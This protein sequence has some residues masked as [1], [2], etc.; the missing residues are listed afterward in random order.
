M[1]RS[2]DVSATRSRG[3][4]PVG[5]EGYWRGCDRARA[6]IERWRLTGV[7]GRTASSRL[8][9]LAVVK[10]RCGRTH[11]RTCLVE[12]RWIC[13]R[14]SM[15]FTF[16][17]YTRAREATRSSLP[18]E[19]LFSLSKGGGGAGSYG[20]V[21]GG[22]RQRRSRCLGS[23]C[24]SLRESTMPRSADVSATRS[25]GAAPVGGEGYWRGCDRARAIIERWRLTG[26]DGRTASSRLRKLA[27]VKL[28][29]GRTHSGLA[30]W[31]GAGFV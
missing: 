24:C 2:A 9:K 3:A 31:S 23:W 22:R 21:G 14:I 1:P 28:R 16:P 26:V 12:R 8:R 30:W 6:I 20:V 5:G 15:P 7:D 18:A 29:C 4:A 27:V 11:S 25:R 13:L 10:L 17:L 19:F